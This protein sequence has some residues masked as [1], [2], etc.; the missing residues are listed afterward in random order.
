MLVIVIENAPPRIHGYLSRL[1]L[2]LRAGVY[3]GQYSIRVRERVW[4]IVEKGIGE[5]NA[6]LAWDAPNDAGFDFETCGTNRRVPVLLDGL[7]LCA[8]SPPIDLGSDLLGGES[9]PDDPRK[10]GRFFDNH[11]KA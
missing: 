10:I 4:A 2:E 7:K 11:I 3:V 8:F 9:L 5:G 6:V 1:F